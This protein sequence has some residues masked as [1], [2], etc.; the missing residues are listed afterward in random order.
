M[1]EP[2]VVMVS[3]R[4]SEGWSLATWREVAA[5]RRQ[6]LQQDLLA[7]I[8]ELEAEEAELAKKYQN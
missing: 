1:P 2:E 6:S 5:T 4:P 7:A 3:G 8:E